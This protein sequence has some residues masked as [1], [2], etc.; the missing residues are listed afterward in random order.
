MKI[1]LLLLPIIL[2]PLFSFAASFDCTKAGSVTEKAICNN[3]TISA[4]DD[5]LSEAYKNA[6]AKTNDE[7]KLKTEQIAWVKESRLCNGDTGCLEK[8]YK[9]RI[10]ALDSTNKPIESKPAEKKAEG[11]FVKADGTLGG[12]DLQVIRVD[13]SADLFIDLRD[14]KRDGGIASVWLISNYKGENLKKLKEKYNASSSKI[15]TQYNCKENT[16]RQKTTIV[17]TGPMLSGTIALQTQASGSSAEWDKE[18]PKSTGQA[19][20]DIVCK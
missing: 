3:P 11:V 17:F 18:Q 20:L 4:L 2:A 14:I 19:I 12:H 13:S 7:V 5:K 8:S 1:K 9:S 10:A 6:K 15:L 16:S